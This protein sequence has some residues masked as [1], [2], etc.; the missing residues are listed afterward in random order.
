MDALVVPTVP[1][2]PSVAEVLAEPI[3]VNTMLGTYTNFVN[4]L[5]L[6]ALTI[7]IGA[8]SATGP[9]MSVTLIGPAWSDEQL[10]VLGSGG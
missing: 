5:D 6:A 9:A 1:R 4:L 3:A 10:V 2:L 7:P 8:A